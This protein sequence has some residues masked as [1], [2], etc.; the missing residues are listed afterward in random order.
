[1]TGSKNVLHKKYCFVLCN[2]E[3][4]FLYKLLNFAYRIKVVLKEWH[5]YLL[6]VLLPTS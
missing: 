1:M 4:Y 5:E 2:E 3:S 6:L